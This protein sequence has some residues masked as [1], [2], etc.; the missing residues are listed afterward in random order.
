M[1]S[2][3]GGEENAAWQEFFG[4]CLPE[5]YLEDYFDNIQ[6]RYVTINGLK[7]GLEI[8]AESDNAIALKNIEDG[9][10]GVDFHIISGCGEFTSRPIFSVAKN[11][12]YKIIVN[13][14]PGMNYG[15]VFILDRQKDVSECHQEV[16]GK[17]D[18]ETRTWTVSNASRATH[19]SLESHKNERNE[20]YYDDLWIYSW[21]GVR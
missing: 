15:M 3:G 2:R 8:C 18:V 6:S 4:K 16:E 21:V 7:Y 10:E 19:N 11:K 9:S 20:E 5:D 17:N 1:N 13:G 14:Y 12:R